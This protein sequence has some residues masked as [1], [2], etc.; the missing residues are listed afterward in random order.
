MSL[1]ETHDVVAIAHEDGLNDLIRAFFTARPR[2]LLYGTNAFVP[3]TTA[4]STNVPTIAFP[5]IPGGIEY[6]V[7]VMPPTID[8]HPD[9]AGTPLP[10]GPDQF[11]V[12]TKVFM[13]LICGKRRR[14]PKT[15]GGTSAGA[16]KVTTLELHVRG[17][18]AA[19]GG[20]LRFA[21]EAV[22]I[23]DIDPD[24]L[25]SFLECLLLMIMQAVLATIRIP[26]DSLSA[27]A[28][29]L[30]LTEGPRIED[31]TVKVFGTI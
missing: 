21:A 3:S 8:L 10:P 12:S 4:T 18:V 23:V 11:T 9:T 1:T 22:E 17:S 16:V 19:I 6:A 24:H 15:V 26:F 13:A 31:D 25:E 5:G 27:G 2:H 20:E 7:L 14:D 29:S 30:T 28:F